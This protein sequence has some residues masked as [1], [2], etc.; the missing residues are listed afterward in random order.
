[1]TDLEIPFEKDRKGHYRFFEILPGA[2]SWSLLFLPLILTFI[3][4]T[5]AVVFILAYLM[6]Y[7]VRSVG[8]VFRAIQGYVTMKQH[9]KL[10]WIAFN[11]DIELGKV[12]SREVERPRWHL[13]NIKRNLSYKKSYKPSDIVHVAMIA[14]VNESREILEL[15]IQSIIDSDYDSKKIILVFAYEGR[16]GKETQA[17]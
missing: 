15:T 10:D 17:C 2:L 14:T 16:A 12:T 8:F 11:E 6:I 1:M 13:D 7:F 3:N 5:A 4:V 9:L